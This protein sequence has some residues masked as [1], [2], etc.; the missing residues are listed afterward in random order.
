GCIGVPTR[1]P[2]ARQGAQVALPA[3]TTGIIVTQVV[4]GSPAAQAGIRVN[5]IVTKVNDQ[6]IDPQHP[7]QS[8]MVKFR[9]GDKV[10][11]ALTRDG[12]EQAVDVTLGQP[13]G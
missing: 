6:L 7:L 12:R 11:L 10:K 9:P 4:P 3:V 2:S 8:L 13:Q 5:D 1:R